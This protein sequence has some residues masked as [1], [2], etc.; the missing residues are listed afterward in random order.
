MGAVIQPVASAIL[1]PIADAIGRRTA[2]ALNNAI[3]DRDAEP[4]LIPTPFGGELGLLRYYPDS[5]QRNGPDAETTQIQDVPPFE[6]GQGDGVDY[7]VNATW[8]ANHPTLGSNQR[9]GQ[10]TGK[11]PITAVPFIQEVG[12]GGGTFVGF[13]ALFS[14][15]TSRNGANEGLDATGSGFQVTISR[16]DGLPDTDGNPQGVPT[17]VT[18]PAAPARVASP[19]I[20]LDEEPPEFPNYQDTAQGLSSPVESPVS[21]NNPLP[22]FLNPD[23]NPF[24]APTA[25]IATAATIAAFLARS[26]ANTRL[27]SR[28]TP[29]APPPARTKSP[30]KC[31]CNKGVVQA[32]SP[33]NGSAPST[34]PGTD[35]NNAALAA[36]LQKVNQIQS[37]AETAWE[38]TRIQK[39]INMLTLIG[40]LHNA[41]MIS[42]DI[43]E[44]MGYVVSNALAVFGVRDENGNALDINGLV[45]SSVT[46]FV[47]NAV[48]EDAY[49]DAISFW[50]R[51]NRV[52]MAASNIMWTIRSINDT[53]QDVLEWIGENTGKIGNA[54]KRYGVVGSRSYGWMSERVRAQDRW[55]RRFNRAFDGLETLEDGASSLGQ[56]TSEVR[57]IQ[58]EIG[59]LGEA[60]QRFRESVA[61][62]NPETV[63]EVSVENTPIATAEQASTA[64]SEAQDVTTLDAVKG[65]N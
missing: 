56:V 48:G 52:L 53:T 6:G 65:G 55:R 7:I 2:D 22:D 16:A 11:G 35:I 17:P 63:P 18:V 38:T 44:T 50:Q 27:G 37:F 62:F 14:D 64:A 21:G 54:L 26:R 4:F 10:A 33:P 15:G 49:N 9:S 23:E 8:T 32:L 1:D 39:L 20:G 34:G 3:P 12:A 31:G 5:P 24:L 28:G 42:R 60:R 45:G 25:A 61:D 59:E 40:V 36:I 30:S 46:T 13:D 19:T 43:G 29:P 57:E 47:K 58:E 51:S 41:A